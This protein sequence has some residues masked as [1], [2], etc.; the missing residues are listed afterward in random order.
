MNVQPWKVIISPTRD[1]RGYRLDLL[2]D[3]QSRPK[4]ETLAEIIGDALADVQFT[5]TQSR[6]SGSLW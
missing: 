4:V 5:D 6:V 3:R 2:S 1:G